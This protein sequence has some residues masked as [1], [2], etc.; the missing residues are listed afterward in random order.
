[1]R[2]PI[3]AI[4]VLSACMPAVRPVA[5]VPTVLRSYELGERQVASIGDPIFDVRA[6]DVYP[7]YQVSGDYDHGEDRLPELR[8]GMVFY[9]VFAEDEGFVLE[10]PNFSEDYGILVRPDGT[11]IGFASLETG[12]ISRFRTGDW[13]PTLLFERTTVVREQEGAFRAQILYS[14]VDGSTLR[15]T[16][17]EFAGDFARPAFSQELQYDL[18]QDSI[19]SFR[20]VRIEVLEAGNT[21]LEYVVEEDGGLPW[22]PRAR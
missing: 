4:L 11:P 21:R 16:Y 7:A 15:T 14:G 3:L 9:A 17:R 1:M 8:R 18:R 6:G 2:R 13:P 5:P 22:L 12:R 20:S 19:I 10:N